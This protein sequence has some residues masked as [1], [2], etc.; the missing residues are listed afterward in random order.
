[1]EG[2]L[3]PS[4]TPPPVAHTIGLPSWSLQRLDPLALVL[5][6]GPSR[7]LI[8]NPPVIS[9]VLTVAVICLLTGALA[10]V[11]KAAV[12]SNE[13]MRKMVINIFKFTVVIII[14]SRVLSFSRP[15]LSVDVNV[16]MWVCVYVRNF[17]VK[18]LGNQR[19]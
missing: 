8:L 1:M 18:Y 7:L 6:L 11:S 3:P 16:C 17:E 15:L 14:G 4:Q 9:T 10:L 2:A 5:D 13:A 19:T 12:H